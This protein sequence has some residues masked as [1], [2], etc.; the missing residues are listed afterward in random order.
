MEGE[1]RRLGTECRGGGSRGTR[2]QPWL[3]KGVYPCRRNIRWREASAFAMLSLQPGPAKSGRS[4]AVL[5]TRLALGCYRLFIQ[6]SCPAVCTSMCCSCRRRSWWRTCRSRWP[7]KHNCWHSSSTSWS[8]SSSAAR[9]LPRQQ[10]QPLRPL[11]LLPAPP[12]RHTAAAS[13]RRRIKGA[14]QAA[15][16]PAVV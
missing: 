11:V 7:A 2:V 3:W 6:A 12:G 5:H 16:G 13:S 9:S 1:G 14:G 15:G 10:P 8:R 4:W